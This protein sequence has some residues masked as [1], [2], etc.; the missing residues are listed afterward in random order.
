MS[1]V[2][3]HPAHLQ[4]STNLLLTGEMCL[5]DFK[6]KTLIV[7][8]TVPLLCHS[9]LFLSFFS[10]LSLPSC[11]PSISPHVLTFLR[12]FTLSLF[13]HTCLS[14]LNVCVCVCWTTAICG[15]TFNKTLSL[16]LNISPEEFIIH[17]P[18]LPFPV[19]V[20]SFCWTS[21]NHLH[22]PSFFMNL[23]RSSLSLIG[24]VG[25]VLSWL[26]ALCDWFRVLR[27]KW[28]GGKLG[29]EFEPWTPEQLR[30]EC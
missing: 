4:S 22:T 21:L 8:T 7:L 3:S 27:V 20:L 28:N 9:H 11:C 17:C 24:P 10:M 2:A 30:T 15:G 5:S 26:L 23:P 16:P 14:F 6:I 19:C 29:R 18:L 1:P 12:H 25:A 13:S